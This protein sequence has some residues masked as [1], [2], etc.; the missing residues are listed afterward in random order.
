MVYDPKERRI[1]ALEYRDRV[2]QH[3]LCDNVLAPLLNRRLIYDNAA[4]RIGKGTHFAMNRVSGF[5]RAFYRQYGAEGY[6]LKCDIRKYFNNIDHDVLKERL[7]GIIRDRGVRALLHCIID[8]Y[9][10]SPGRGLPL[11]NQSSQWFALYYMDGLDRLVKE[12]L[13]IRY[14]SRYMDDMILIHNDRAYLKECLRQMRRLI[15]DDL[16]LSFNEKTQIM[17][18]RNGFDYL[19]FHFYL[20]ETGKVIR[21]VRQQTKKKYKRRLRYFQYAYAHGQI[22][23]SDITPVINSYHA[24][25]AHGHTYHLQKAVLQ[26][27]VLHRTTDVG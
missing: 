25:M 26:D 20:T 12:R 16:H 9:E 11:G 13:R 5:L 1:D 24:H 18:L 10:L 7:S 17:P 15:E 27:F 3:C 6:V 4:C 2:V 8:S 21:K 19:G 23:L 22:N 14:Y